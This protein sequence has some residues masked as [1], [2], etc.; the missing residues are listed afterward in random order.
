[1]A[2]NEVI[3]FSSSSLDS[4]MFSLFFCVPSVMSRSRERIGCW[5]EPSLSLDITSW[6]GGREEG[7]R[8][9]GE[10]RGGRRGE[11]GRRE[12]EELG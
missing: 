6:G 7:G 8:R 2:S 9:E 10:E 12:G 4:S 1:M 11:K 5:M 3:S